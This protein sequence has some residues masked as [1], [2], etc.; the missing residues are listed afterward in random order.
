MGSHV[1]GLLGYRCSR[2]HTEATSAR[3]W[4]RATCSW[5][6]ATHTDNVIHARE[7]GSG[8]RWWGGTR[9]GHAHHRRST[10]QRG[11]RHH[12]ESASP[13]P[14]GTLTPLSTSPGHHR[15]EFQQVLP[16]FPVYSVTDVPGCTEPAGCSSAR[17][18]A[19]SC[20]QVIDH[21]RSLALER[22]QP[23]HDPPSQ[24]AVIL[25]ECARR[26]EVN[27]RVAALSSPLEDR[28]RE[29]CAYAGAPSSWRHEELSKPWC[30]FGA[31]REVG[32]HEV[33]RPEQLSLQDGH[34][35]RRHCSAPRRLG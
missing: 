11:M 7:R 19:F 16:M 4:H 30:Q 14:Q 20:S 23:F 32:G 10:G 5:L 26:V 35:N 13:S 17:F 34:E 21:D 15:L 18:G 24:P 12:A 1:P 3:R 25:R 9:Y 29:G 28:A 6:A 31:G 27:A 2:L 33:R 8:E 22:G